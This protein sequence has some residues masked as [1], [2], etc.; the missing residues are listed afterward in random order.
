MGCISTHVIDSALGRPAAGLAVSLHRAGGEQLHPLGR[1]TTD[2]EGRIAELLASG[3]LEAGEH[4]LT[5]ETGRYF[6]VRGIETLY[7]SVTIHV[8]V[9]DVSAHY[10]LPLLL[11]P[12]GYTTYRGS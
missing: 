6:A 10:H 9:R 3:P 7:P 11:G 5:F 1:G 2:A 8:H 12:H 4:V